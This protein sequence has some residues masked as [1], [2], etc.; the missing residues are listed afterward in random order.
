MT[1]AMLDRLQQSSKDGQLGAMSDLLTDM[2]AWWS[3]EVP[4]CREG[5]ER[6]PTPL[7]EMMY[8]AIMAD[9]ERRP[10]AGWTGPF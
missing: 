4:L 9:L 10:G 2:V 7:V 3:L 6:L 5:V 1:R 8:R